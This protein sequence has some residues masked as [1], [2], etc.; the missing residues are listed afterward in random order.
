M[1]NTREMLIAKKRIELLQGK[2]VVL[3]VNLGRNRMVEYTGRVEEI[4]QGIF[5]VRDTSDGKI[6]SYPYSD[7]ITKN[8]KF[9]QNGQA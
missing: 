9:Y 6:Y 4:Y 3:K 1:S 8:I 2:D 7:L 5:T